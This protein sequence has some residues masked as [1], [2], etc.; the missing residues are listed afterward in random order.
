LRRRWATQGNAKLAKLTAQQVQALYSAK[1][2]EGLSQTTVNHL[3]ACLRAA[4][5][6]AVRLDLVPR[7]VCDLVDP[8]RMAQHEMQVLSAEQARVLLDTCTGDRL[9]ALYVVALTTGMRLGEML[10]MRWS[11]IDLESARPSI[12][13]HTALNRRG[14]GWTLKETKTKRSRRRIALTSQAVEAL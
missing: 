4:L 12:E 6:A 2:K 7:N 10:G 1:L 13:V 14:K 8:P 9:E 3:H 11:D 5:K